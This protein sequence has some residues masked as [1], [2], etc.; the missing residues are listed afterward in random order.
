MHNGNLQ[1]SNHGQ[2][3]TLLFFLLPLLPL[4]SLLIM[5][6]V[7][8]IPAAAAAATAPA[9]LLRRFRVILAAG[10]LL[11]LYL[12]GIAGSETCL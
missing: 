10:L 2:V 12:F 7:L 6:V 1:A 9:E 5:L 4:H 11:L 3:L 8:N